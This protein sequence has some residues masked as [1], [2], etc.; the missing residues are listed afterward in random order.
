MEV[1][2][3]HIVRG[4]KPLQIGW[5][6]CTSQYWYC[7]SGLDSRYMISRLRP[8]DFQVLSLT[9]IAT[10]H[11][12]RWFREMRRNTATDSIQALRLPITPLSKLEVCSRFFQCNSPTDSLCIAERLPQIYYALERFKVET[13]GFEQLTRKYMENTFNPATPDVNDVQCVIPYLTESPFMKD[14]RWVETS[15]YSYGA[16]M[17]PSFWSAFRLSHRILQQTEGYNDGLVSVASS[18]WGDY[19]G[20]LDGVS[21]LDLI[22]WSN[23]LKRL[24]LE[25]T[26]NKQTCVP[27]PY[28]YRSA[29]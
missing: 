2:Y 1:L 24:A 14:H 4:E 15:Y 5:W 12:G 19:K 16:T 3:L 26:G 11:R 13:A 21:H 29:C 17:Q 10:P 7:P 6:I 22:N 20:T 28:P 8:T 25:I 23:R 18:R 9:T 27:T